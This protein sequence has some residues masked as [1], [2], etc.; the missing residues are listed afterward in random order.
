MNASDLDDL[1]PVIGYRATRIIVAW[2]AGRRFHVPG[3][4]RPGHPL[5][6][7]LGRPAFVALVGEFA[8][9]RVNVPAAD[10]EERYGRDRRIAE[11][12]ASGWACERVAAAVGITARRVEQIR[13]EL[14][15]N[16]WLRYAQG[17]DSAMS[18]SRGRRRR[19]VAP[20]EFFGTNEVFHEPPGGSES[21]T[22]A[23]RM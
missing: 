13:R 19:P 2:F 20:P 9:C 22:V 14:V 1:C 8:L 18:A 21:V 3:T 15:A 6:L 23:H 12:L 16:G 5:E 7:L 4:T 17:F 10:H 11:M